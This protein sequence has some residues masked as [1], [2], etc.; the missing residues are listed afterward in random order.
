MTKMSNLDKGNIIFLKYG[1]FK[2]NPGKF[3]INTKHMFL[4]TAH[5]TDGIDTDLE[6]EDYHYEDQGK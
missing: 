3:L 5:V 6:L 2:N 1:T 4:I